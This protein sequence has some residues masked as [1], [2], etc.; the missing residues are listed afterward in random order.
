MWV[1][2]VFNAWRR[3]MKIAASKYISN[4]HKKDKKTLFS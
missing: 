4:M 2:N 3:C 1:E